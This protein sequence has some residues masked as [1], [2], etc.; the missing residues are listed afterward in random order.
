M[1]KAIQVDTEESISLKPRNRKVQMKHIKSTDG[2][3]IE[4]KQYTLSEL[5][6][7]QGKFKRIDTLLGLDEEKNEGKSIMLNMRTSVFEA[8]K[9]HIMQLLVKHPAVKTVNPSRTAKANTEDGNE[10]DIEYHLDVELE[11]EGNEHPLKLKIYNTNCRIQ[12]QHVGKANHKEQSYLGNRCPPKF[13]AEEVLIPMCKSIQDT[14]T[15][16][17]EKQFVAHLRNEIQRL[18]RTRKT[19][20]SNKGQCLM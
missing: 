12:I 3:S 13:F 20:S 5:S 16:D 1:T 2:I 11:V 6:G 9:M 7:L 17:D 14:I 10:A 4:R 8:M 15:D 18:K 19:D